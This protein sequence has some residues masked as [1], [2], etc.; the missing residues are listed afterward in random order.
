MKKISELTEDVQIDCA[1]VHEHDSIIMSLIDNGYK[2]ADFDIGVDDNS[3]FV[4]PSI[5]VRV[6][7]KEY[8]TCVSHRSVNDKVSAYINATDFLALSHVTT[9]PNDPQTHS[10]NC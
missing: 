7:D 3:F 6:K 9:N 1:T 10:A 8:Y 4:F 5:I 2:D